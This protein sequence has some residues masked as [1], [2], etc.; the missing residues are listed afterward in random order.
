MVERAGN[1]MRRG[2][3][4]AMASPGAAAC[5]GVTF[6]RVVRWMSAAPAALAGVSRVKGSIRTG[7]D[8]DLVIW[9]PDVDGTIDSASLY[10]RHPLC[11]YVGM[12]TR[13]SVRTTMLRG[14][15]I[16]RDGE[17]APPRGTQIGAAA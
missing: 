17:F 11:P 9:D 5:R 13:G 15:T 8:A 10:H 7:A 12:A 4:A 3:A 2:V 14:Q 6:E 16:Y 1:R